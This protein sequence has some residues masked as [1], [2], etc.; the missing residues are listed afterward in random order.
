V[1][2]A[3]LRRDFAEVTLAARIRHPHAIF[4]EDD[5]PIFVCRKPRIPLREL[6]PG[7]RDFG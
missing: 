6:W 2:E 3:D 5:I 7:T 4:Y 1:G